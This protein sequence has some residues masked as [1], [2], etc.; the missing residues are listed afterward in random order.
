MSWKAFTF[1]NII[2][3][4][5][6]GACDLNLS[7]FAIALTHIQPNILVDDE[8]HARITDFGLAIVAQGF[9]SA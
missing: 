3:G 5:L 4:D 6:K 7:R 8:G 2:R 1:C 9:D